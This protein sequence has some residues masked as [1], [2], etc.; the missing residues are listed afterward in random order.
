MKKQTNE[1]KLKEISKGF[2]NVIVASL[3]KNETENFIEDQTFDLVKIN[4]VSKFPEIICNND[5]EDL[6]DIPEEVININQSEMQIQINQ[7]QEQIK[8]FLKLSEESNKINEDL[9]NENKKLK[10][11]RI[12]FAEAQRI[13]KRKSL[14]LDNLAKF[15]NIISNIETLASVNVDMDIVDN[16]KLSI[17]FFS[18]SSYRD[19]PILKTSNVL[20][21]TEF[22][23]FIT[24]KIQIKIKLLKEEIENM[25]L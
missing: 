7:M 25:L 4:H 14:L 15:E 17:A 24:K 10:S 16:D 21:I 6:K 2:P 23:E 13:I 5:F 1:Q 22:I 11:R 12:D 9:I 18:K 19:E 20:I 8:E 3:Q